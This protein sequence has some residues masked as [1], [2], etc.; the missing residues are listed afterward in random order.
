MNLQQR[1]DLLARLGKYLISGDAGWA[2]AKTKASAE[3]AWFIPEFVELA[4]NH[5]ALEWLEK[6]KLEKWVAPYGLPEENRN[7]KTIGLVMAGNIPLVGF[8][9]F[10]SVF[11]SGNRQR[12]K[13][14]S[15]DNILLRQLVGQLS[16]WD[17]EVEDLVVF[18]DRLK[19]C[20]AY[21]ATGSNNSSRYF[22]YYF[23]SYPHIIRR[24][25]TSAAILDGR[26]SPAALEKL[27]DDVFLYFGLGCRNITKLYLPPGYDFVP[28]LKS[29][30]KYAFLKENH[31][32]RNNYDYQLALFILNKQYYMTNQALLLSE[33][34]AIFSPIAVLH[35]EY[36]E[37]AE[38]VLKEL[39]DNPDIQCL[40]GL[41]NI[42]FGE[43]QRPG[44]TDY[45]DGIDTLQFLLDN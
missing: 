29:F 28:L 12:I 45:A 26:E 27:A 40:V 42:P 21:I 22:D 39:K 4:A 8:H 9:D 7:P 33:N 1:I 24:N 35:Y 6:D 38:S 19:G 23:N 32:Y 41:E 37:E 44:L 36:Y 30:D 43:V 34:K 3:N 31:K 20:N 17:P 14:S 11:I 2:A 5:I 10:L 25:R 18:S 16:G 15:K 13:P